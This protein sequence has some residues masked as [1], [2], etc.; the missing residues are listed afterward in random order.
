[1]RCHDRIVLAH[2]GGGV[3]TR[4]LID[5]VWRATFD[6]PALQH[7]PDGA[8]LDAVRAPDGGRIAFTTDSYVVKPI[9]FRGGD[10]GRLAVCGTVNDL[11]VT[12]ARPRYISL[13]AIIEEGFALDDLRRVAD[14][15]AAAAREAGVRIVTGDTKVVEAGAA[16]GLFLTTAGVGFVP[17]G[18]ETGPH[19]ARPGDAVIVSGT[20]GDHGIALM[21]EREGLAFGTPVSSDCAPL[22]GLGGLVEAVYDSGAAPHAMRDPTRGGLAATLYEIAEASGV[23]VELDEA[24][25][26]VR[27]EVR[28]ACEMLGLDPLTVANEGKLVAVVPA[29]DADRALA[30]ARAHPLG[31]DAALV[32]RVVERRERPLILKTRIGGERIVEMPYGEELPR[33]C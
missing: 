18:R 15:A 2:G 6:D 22:G 10:I 33:I 28:G 9:F 16:D 29:D 5:D 8:V 31:K 1:M 24:A 17:E 7:L 25:I 27:S 26:P 32:G 12:G 30:A 13:A 14:S 19:L 11:A 21:A 4:R 20:I 23:T 3:L